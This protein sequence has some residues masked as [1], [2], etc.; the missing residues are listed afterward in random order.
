M[1]KLQIN[2]RHSILAK[3]DIQYLLKKYEDLYFLSAVVLRLR[4][5]G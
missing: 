2:R 3:G 1:G 5:C 4:C